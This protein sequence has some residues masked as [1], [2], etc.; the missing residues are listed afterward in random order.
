MTIVVVAISTH[1]R[2]WWHSRFTWAIIRVENEH[3][4][5]SA[6][7]KAI[8]FEPLP[9]DVRDHLT[10]ITFNNAATLGTVDAGTLNAAADDMEPITSVATSDW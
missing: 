1:K 5:N 3:L 6:R 10:N 2:L 4:I 8:E 7:Y 9:F